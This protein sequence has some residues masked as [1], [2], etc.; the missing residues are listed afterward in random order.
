M[1]ENVFSQTSILTVANEQKRYRVRLIFLR[2]FF[3]QRAGKS[4]DSWFGSFVHLPSFVMISSHVTL[5]SI[6]HFGIIVE[7]RQKPRSAATPSAAERTGGSGA[8]F[9]REE[10]WNQNEEPLRNVEV[11]VGHMSFPFVKLEND[12]QT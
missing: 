5:A 2:L 4:L 9:V 12:V 11:E 6:R 10:S 7:Q 3:L 1:Q 8:D